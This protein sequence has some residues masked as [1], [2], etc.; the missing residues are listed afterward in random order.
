M[1]FFDREQEIEKLRQIEELSHKVSQFTV[2]SGR[3][4]IGKTSLVKEAYRGFPLLYFFVARKAESEL[5]ETFIETI[6]QMLDVPVAGSPKRFAEVFRFVMEIAK[7][8]HVTLVI[9][10][11]QEFYRVNRSIYSEMQD[12]WDSNKNEA[13]VNLLVCGSVNALLNKIF[14]DNKEPLYGRQT[15]SLRIDAFTTVVLKEI[16]REYAPKYSKEDLLSLYLLTGGVAKYVELLVDGDCLTHER[17][18]NAFFEKDSYFLGEGK[19]MLIDE[20]G[21]EYGVYFSIISLIAQG[22]NTRGDIE[23]RLGMEL[24]GYLKKLVDDYGLISK[25]QPMFE[26]AI[27]KNVHYAVEDSFLRFWFRFVHK[28]SYIIEAGGLEKLRELVKRDYATY[29]GMVLE[30]YFRNSMIESGEYTRI[31]YW[32]DRNGENEIDIIAADE[33]KKKVKICEVKR[34]K[35]EVDMRILTEKAGVFFQ[36]TKKYGRYQVEYQGL[37]MEEM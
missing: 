18:L 35:K 8:Q 23:N 29:S 34:Q 11:F 20:F 32:H 4:R 2:I 33:L 12:I 25:Q 5:C 36:T 30:Q 28:Y 9:D 3:R 16:M 7:K 15:N 1:K 24:G 13:S 6:R 10:E 21:K 22:H 27:N 19:N 17:M 14:R 26:T 37:S 31:G